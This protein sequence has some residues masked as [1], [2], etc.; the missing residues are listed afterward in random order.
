MAQKARK[1]RK[2]GWR[3][4]STVPPMRHRQKFAIAVCRGLRMSGTGPYVSAHWAAI[5]TGN[6]PFKPEDVEGLLTAAGTE[7]KFTASSLEKHIDRLARN[8][9]RAPETDWERMSALAIKALILAARTGNGEVYCWTLDVLIGLGWRDV[10]ERLRARIE[11]LA[12]SNVPPREGKLG[13]EGQ[14]LL[15]QLR[16]AARQKP[17]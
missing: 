10:I 13:R 3:K 16:A 6:E 12:K 7:I 4:G 17:K 8:A 11:D 5:V 2:P 14:A 9:D 1:R 15:N